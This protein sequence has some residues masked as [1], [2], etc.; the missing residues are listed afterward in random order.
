MLTKKDQSWRK[1]GFKE[2]KFC[3]LVGCRCQSGVGCPSLW[4]P[5][6]PSQHRIVPSSLFLLF[7]DHITSHAVCH[8]TKKL[9]LASVKE[10]SNVMMTPSD[11][12]LS[13]L[14]PLPLAPPVSLPP[15]P[16]LLLSLFQWWGPRGGSTGE[17][18]R[19]RAGA[20]GNKCLIIRL[21]IIPGGSQSGRR[22]KRGE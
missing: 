21:I 2:I 3:W 15:S 5:P 14:Q 18:E 10:S 8:H 1:S 13:S 22:R 7:W 9:P 11:L 19:E 16:A 6:A 17:R 12:L 4:L 20:V